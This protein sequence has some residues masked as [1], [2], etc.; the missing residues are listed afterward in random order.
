MSQL[1]GSV[2]TLQDC[3]YGSFGKIENQARHVSRSKKL[4]SSVC[5]IFALLAVGPSLFAASA[6]APTT[7]SAY[8]GTDAKP[9]P[10]AP[11]LVLLD[12]AKFGDSVVDGQIAGRNGWY[13]EIVTLG[14][15]DND[16][17]LARRISFGEMEREFL[18]DA[19]LPV[20][21]FIDSPAFDLGVQ[22]AKPL[23]V[24]SIGSPP[25]N[26]VRTAMIALRFDTG[27]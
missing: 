8:S 6:T 26:V 24:G 11:P 14:E 23:L 3:R 18:P 27:P 5:V 13:P 2:E 17:R 22:V 10:H 25:G 1:A 12:G 15:N 7:Y 20:V 9:I 21:S 19:I 4:V 16:A